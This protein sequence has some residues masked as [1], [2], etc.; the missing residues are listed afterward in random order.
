MLVVYDRGRPALYS[1]TLVNVSVIDVNDNEPK[2]TSDLYE[3]SV[4]EDIAV[5][6]TVT[7]ELHDATLQTYF[8][9]C[10]SFYPC[11][12]SYSI[13]SLSADLFYATPS[14]AIRRSK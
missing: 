3:T 8:P 10:C 2:F 9:Y 12:A 7:R 1:S 5:G 14:A 4:T 6:L 11:N 13:A